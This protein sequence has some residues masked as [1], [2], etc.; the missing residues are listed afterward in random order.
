MFK[1]IVVLSCSIMLLVAACSSAAIVPATPVVPISTAMNSTAIPASVTPVPATLA[2]N[3]TPTAAQPSSNG[4][5]ASFGP[6]S[7]VLPPGLARGISG[8]PIPR[9]E[10]QDL[11][12]WEMTPGH[13]VI[14]LDGYPLQ[15]KFHQPQIFVYPAQAYAEMVPSA[16]EAIHR[17]DNILYG[18]SA[19]I[20]VGQL[21]AVPSFNAQQVFASNVQKVPFQNGG[22]VRFVTEYA[23]YPASVNNHDLFYEFQGVTRDGEYYIVAILPMS[24]PALAATSDAGAVLP[25][26]GVPYPDLN[27]PN[28][29]LPGYYSAVTDLL[30]AQSPAAF[31]PSIEQLDALIQSM[32]ITPQVSAS[33]REPGVSGVARWGTQ[34]VPN[35]IVELRTGDWRTNPNAVLQRELTDPEGRY[36]MA[37]PPAGDYVMCG[38][39]PEGAQERS[40]CTP[41]HIEAG[42][43]VA[44]I[45][46][47]LLRTVGIVA[48]PVDLLVVAQPTLSWASFPNAA[49]YEVFVVDAGTTEL[50]AHEFVADPQYTV[51]AALQPGRTYDWEVNAVAADGGLLADGESR[52]VMQP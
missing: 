33:P 11:P 21:P 42:Q 7:L 10:G 9:N 28:P 43:D 27:A 51:M 41:V 22:G 23:Q 38:L 14:K 12:Y 29:D 19:P 4:T 39:F 15:G 40:T 17:L 47:M 25:A 52:F 48:P 1:K 45:D 30:N 8:D 13:T 50:L 37:N 3:A 26:G 36:F 18:P 34:P 46:V 44:G 5:T 2:P 35:A 32:R 6:V 24:H 16:F 31:A 49:Q 20:A